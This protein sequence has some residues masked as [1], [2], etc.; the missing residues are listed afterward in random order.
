MTH[1]HRSDLCWSFRELAQ[2]TMDKIDRSLR[3]GV[4]FNEETITES[5]LLKLAE[6]HFHQGLL[7]RAWSKPE[8]GTGTK[9]TYGLPTGADWDLWIRDWTGA[10]IHLRVQAKK[11]FKSG[12]YESLDGTGQQIK[13]LRNN[14]GAAVP[15]Y[16][17]YNGRKFIPLTSPCSANCSPQFRAQTVWGCTVAPVTSVPAINQPDPSQLGP[18]HPWHCLVCPC[19]A[20]AGGVSLPGRIASVLRSFYMVAGD[21]GDDERFRG[22][23]AL[24]FELSH[25]APPWVAMLEKLPEAEDQLKSYLADSKLLGVALIAQTSSDAGEVEESTL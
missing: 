25:N 4:S 11:Q 12:R 18:V 3:Y 19:Q 16:I 5:L 14:C 8:E 10:G 17:L 1:V 23:S 2:W 15:I 13:D 20:S 24:S 6:R 22:A 21:A 7:I 9:A